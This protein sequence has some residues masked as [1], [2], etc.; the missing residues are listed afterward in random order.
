MPV[1]RSDSP[2]EYYDPQ[3]NTL[4]ELLKNISEEIEDYSPQNSI[5]AKD[6]ISAGPSPVATLSKQLQQMT[7]QA[8]AQRGPMGNVVT[9]SGSEVKQK[10]TSPKPK[11]AQE[12]FHKQFTSEETKPKQN[13]SISSDSSISSSGS[14]PRRASQ[15]NVPSIQIS[16]T[17]SQMETKY[18]T[19]DNPNSRRNSIKS[20]KEGIYK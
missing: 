18:K 10:L 9:K 1:S 16:R 7:A 8:A 12:H 5:K 20:F 13:M 3:T 15:P 19:A 17:E 4:L 2:V 6:S 11:V 14:A